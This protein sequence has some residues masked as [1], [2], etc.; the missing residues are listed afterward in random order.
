MTALGAAAV[1]HSGSGLGGHTNEKAV[2]LGTAAAVGLE[3]AL[4]HNIYPVCENYSEKSA[5]FKSC[6]A[7]LLGEPLRFYQESCDLLKNSF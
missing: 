1:E 2:N 6:E 3:R 4:G 5:V 7:V